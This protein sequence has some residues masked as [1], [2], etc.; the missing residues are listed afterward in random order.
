MILNSREFIKCRRWFIVRL[1]SNFRNGTHKHIRKWKG[2]FI[3]WSICANM[4][5]YRHLSIVRIEKIGYNTLNTFTVKRRRRKRRRKKT[6]EKGQEWLCEK[7]FEMKRKKNNQFRIY[8]VMKRNAEELT[9]SKHQAENPMEW[10]EEHFLL[11]FFFFFFK[12]HEYNETVKSKCIACWRNCLTI[13]LLLL[14][15]HHHFSFFQ[16]FSLIWYSIRVISLIFHQF[17]SFIWIRSILVASSFHC[18]WTFVGFVC[19]RVYVY[20]ID[21]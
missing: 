10:E 11:L 19:V 18:S 7:E 2:K 20:M 8:N 15:H 21:R 4:N 6:I 1:N 17:L 14:L 3:D 16:A 12:N 13:Q 5:A 9:L